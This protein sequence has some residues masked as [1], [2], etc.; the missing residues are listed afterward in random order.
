MKNNSDQHDNESSH[1]FP[2]LEGFPFEEAFEDFAGNKRT[3]I[4]SCFHTGEGYVMDAKEKGKEN[5][6]EFSAYSETSP[7][8]GQ[9]RKKMK[10]MMAIRHLTM[11]QMSV[12]R[13]RLDEK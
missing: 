1:E 12:L 4:L 8:F 5:G 2:M 11:K 13:T 3:F 7:P 6:Y 10:R 9:L